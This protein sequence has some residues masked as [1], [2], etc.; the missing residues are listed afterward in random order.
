MEKTP[1]TFASKEEERKYLVDLCD[2]GLVPESKWKNRDTFL[3]QKKLA[4][5]EWF[6]LCGCKYT[7][8]SWDE[9]YIQICLYA[10]GFMYFEEGEPEN[11]DFSIPSEERLNQL[12]GEDWY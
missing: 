7:I 11:E 8:L 9:Y 12:K 5:C 10:H 2:R 6:L 1:K 4:L 3:F